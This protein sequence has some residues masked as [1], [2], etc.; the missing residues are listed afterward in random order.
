MAAERDLA[1]PPL[2]RAKYGKDRFGKEEKIF[3][4]Q[5][6]KAGVAEEFDG[7]LCGEKLC[8]DVDR[9]SA[10]DR[11]GHRISWVVFDDAA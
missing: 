6:L 11:A 1:E 10:N 4:C 8:V 7:R 9:A 5:R 2:R 3:R